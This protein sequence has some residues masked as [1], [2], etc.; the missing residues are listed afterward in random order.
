[1]KCRYFDPQT[2]TV[3]GT[4]ASPVQFYRDTSFSYAPI[5]G[6]TDA[7][8]DYH[9]QGALPD[10]GDGSVSLAPVGYTVTMTLTEM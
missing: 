7:S 5:G 9:P 10:S 8:G 4:A 1:M 6:W 3:K 2:G